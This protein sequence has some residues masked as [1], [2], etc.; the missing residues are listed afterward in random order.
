M[1]DFSMG[2]W[3]SS[4]SMRSVELYPASCRAFFVEIYKQQSTGLQYTLRRLRFSMEQVL[5]LTILLLGRTD[6]K[7]GVFEKAEPGADESFDA[8]P[9][10]GEKDES[11]SHSQ[12]STAPLS[13]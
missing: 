13:V 1:L 11:F 8:I 4:L 5:P 6:Q 9:E 7:H 3:E 10:H 2:T 12:S